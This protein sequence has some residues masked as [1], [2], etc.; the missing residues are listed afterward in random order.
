M[1]HLDYNKRKREKQG[2]SRNIN[3]FIEMEK[4]KTLEIKDHFSSESENIEIHVSKQ[5]FR[6]FSK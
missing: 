3:S 5:R 1:K 4:G 6:E 2:D